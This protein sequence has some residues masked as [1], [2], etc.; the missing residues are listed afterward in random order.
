MGK[1]QEDD[2]RLVLLGVLGA[3]VLGV[4]LIP[5]R[6]LTPAA[7]LVF[8]F[9]LLTIAVAEVGG[10][11]PV[12]GTALTSAL[13]LDF[14]L[15]QPYL[16]FAIDDK[17]DAL[18]FTGLAVCGLTVAGFR[19]WRARREQAPTEQALHLDLLR[20]NLERLGSGQAEEQLPG[21][22]RELTRALPLAAVV[23]RDAGGAVLFAEGTPH[24][25][26]PAALLDS[27][28][29]HAVDDAGPRVVGPIMPLPA[30]GARIPLQ[31]RGRSVGWLEVWGDGTPASPDTRRTVVDLS[32]VLAAALQR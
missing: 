25:R 15:T 26:P 13:S 5:L 12:V 30:T 32:R 7:N 11:M 10:A 24:D 9:L 1:L 8:P 29:L 27:Q 18:A 31:F 23:V 3:V 21:L 28:T 20:T 4:L 19:A 2:I 22:L 17:H 16:T 6:E 14:F